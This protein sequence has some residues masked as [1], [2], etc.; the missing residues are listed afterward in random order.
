MFFIH[1]RETVNYDYERTLEDP[2]VAHSL[3]LDVDPYGNVIRS[4]AIAYGRRQ[5]DLSILSAGDR[6]EQT[7]IH[8]TCSE[9][10][11]TD[12]A[13]GNDIRRTPLPSESRNYELTGL[14]LPLTSLR[15]TFDE[16]R[17]AVVASAV[18]IAYEAKPTAG[19]LQKRL[20]EH[21]RTRYRPDDL[22]VSLGDPMALLPLGKLES[23]GIPGESYQLVFTPGLVTEVYGARVTNSML[24]N[25]CRYGH[26]EGDLNWWIP[27]GR[28]FYSPGTADTAA[29]ELAQ[30]RAH[31]FLARRY[32]HPF[33]TSAFPTEVFVSFDP[34]NLLIQETRDALDNRVTAGE[35][36]LD[37]TLPLVKRG[38][39]YRVLQAKL[40]MDPDRNRFAAAFD[41][42]GMVVGTAV[43]GKPPP[44]AVEGDSLEGLEADLTK[45]AIINHL[46]NPLA[47][48]Q[49]VSRRATTR[50][51]YDL[52]A[53]LRTK[54]Q[55]DPQPAVVY[56]L[57]RETHDSDPV[58]A[59]GLKIQHS[60]SYSDGLGREIQKKIQAEPGK[61]PQRDSNGKVIVG[62]DGQPMMTPDEISPRWVGSGWMVFNNKGKPVRQDRAILHR[63]SPF[64]TFDVRIGVSPVLFYDLSTRSR[65]TKP[66]SHLG[67]NNIRS[68]AAGNLGCQRHG[69]VS[70]R[71]QDRS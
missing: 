21:I 20:V 28:T 11:F 50:L 64:R 57:A 23:L 4:A 39:D 53:Y 12:M 10:R 31:F 48:P 66:Q 42:L 29:Q 9:N 32:G 18:E 33:H 61:V 43:M 15:F 68:V 56:N 7:Q 69:R 49:S 62:E 54:D 63:H 67:E 13:S 25:E 5:P 41:A 71:S 47:D 14:S 37:P 1:E 2:R 34:Y 38:H 51:V 44:A 70:D 46:Q 58:L 45:A 30:A 55:P 59:G 16:V 3:A 52:F 19:T 35:R 27:T 6:A 22:G 40:L 36:N 24:S 17:S 8:L 65:Y 60:F 26:S